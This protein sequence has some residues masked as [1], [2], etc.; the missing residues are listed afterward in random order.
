MKQLWVIQKM[1]HTGSGVC[2]CRTYLIS[3]QHYYVNI[4][5]IIVEI[6]D[7]VAP[8]IERLVVRILSLSRSHNQGL[9]KVLKAL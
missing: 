1:L 4:W 7:S 8:S 3:F 6:V 2:G 9:K 5:R